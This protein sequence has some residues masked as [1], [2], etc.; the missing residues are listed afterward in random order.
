MDKS[1]AIWASGQQLAGFQL[2]TL[3][4]FKGL[5]QN[6]MGFLM[7]SFKM[8]RISELQLRASR[9]SNNLVDHILSHL[10]TSGP[11]MLEC[12]PVPLWV[13]V[14]TQ[15]AHQCQKSRHPIVIGKFAGSTIRRL[16]FGQKLKESVA[17]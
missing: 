12:K 14:H 8:R 5:G 7:I 4:H 17:Q 16:C 11:E 2:S 10:D 1:A 13:R 15:C 3:D 9:L 6:N